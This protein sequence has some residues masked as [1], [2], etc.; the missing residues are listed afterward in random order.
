MTVGEARRGTRERHG[1]LL[2]L[3]R[4]GTTKV[5]ELADALG[6]SVSTVRRDL[7]R[8]TS[9]GQVART[10]GGAITQETFHE[11]SIGES[12]RMRR[13][14]KA[15]IAAEAARLVADATTVLVDAGTTCAALAELLRERSQLT[16]VTRGLEAANRLAS[17]A[18]TEVIL[19]GGLVRRLSH[20]LVGPLTEL[21]L[22]RLSF[23]T[24]FLGADAVDPARG[25][26]E[27]TLEEILVKEQIAAASL[28]VFVLADSS[29]LVG[30]AGGPPAWTNLPAG[31]SLITDDEI[32]ARAVEDFTAHGVKLIVAGR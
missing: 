12:A 27:P 8:L 11:R 4:T 19:L 9:S 28:K 32:N 3:V 1:Q 14:A 25:I 30:V 21:A 13:Q 2:A 31:W 17:S 23:H 6:V 20:G 15:A 16:V 5:E 22:Q 29:K 10:Y 7:G 18:T 26:G 24:A